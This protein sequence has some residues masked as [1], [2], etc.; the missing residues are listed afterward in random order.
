MTPLYASLA[1]LVIWTAQFTV[2]YGVTAVACARG[3]GEKTLFGAG[4]I[5]LAVIA[6]TLIALAMNGVV[7]VRAIYQTR[8]LSA[9]SAVPADQFL[10]HLTT[11]ISGLCIAAIAWNGL[12]A[13]IIPVC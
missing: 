7:L 8:D 13:L 9:A 4:L 12:P 5:S 6:A 3:Y 2:I 10:A 11:L 1:G